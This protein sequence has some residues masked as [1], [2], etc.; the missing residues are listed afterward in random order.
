MLDTLS[1]V[2]THYEQV[3]LAAINT[4]STIRRPARRGLSTFSP[5][6]QHTY[7]EWQQLRGGR[8]RI[9]SSRSSAAFATSTLT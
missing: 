8:D 5:A 3:E 1:V 9:K 4:G 2:Q 7:R 6:H